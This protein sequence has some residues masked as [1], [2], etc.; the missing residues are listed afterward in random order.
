MQKHF[1]RTTAHQKSSR[2]HHLCECFHSLCQLHKWMREWMSS[3]NL[4]AGI[5]T[6]PCVV[7]V[8]QPNS[9][10]YEADSL[11]SERL[12]C[13]WPLQWNQMTDA[14]RA[15][16]RGVFHLNVSPAARKLICVGV[17]GMMCSFLWRHTLDKLLMTCKMCSLQFWSNCLV[18]C[19]LLISTGSRC[20]GW[21]LRWHFLFCVKSADGSDGNQQH[22][23]IWWFIR[24]IFIVSGFLSVSQ[25]RSWEKM[26]TALIETLRVDHITKPHQRHSE[27]A[28]L[29]T[30]H[31]NRRLDGD[32]RQMTVNIRNYWFILNK[33]CWWEVITL[34]LW[35]QKHWF[36]RIK[37]S[38]S[39]S[40]WWQKG[41]IFISKQT[42]KLLWW[43]RPSVPSPQYLQVTTEEC[44]CA[45]SHARIL[46]MGCSTFLQCWENL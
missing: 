19:Y 8:W 30:L 3:R 18:L 36:R 46:C 37:H 21:R 15:D 27:G 20:R 14:A 22:I 4:W 12:L 33:C 35:I 39:S 41:F 2:Q 9:L 32:S 26:L 42:N 29:R 16:N 6:H 5:T 11:R 34:C 45:H 31:G 17:K 23:K 7:F 44:S 10:R 40:F 38:S 24:L 25:T 1:Q 13:L 43:K 28:S